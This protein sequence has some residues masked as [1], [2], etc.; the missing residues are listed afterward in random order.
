MTNK[1]DYV[2]PFEDY[3]EMKMKQINPEVEENSTNKKYL[4]PTKNDLLHNRM[5]AWDSYYER[6]K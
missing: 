4:K 2:E 3:I 5:D 1:I 6:K